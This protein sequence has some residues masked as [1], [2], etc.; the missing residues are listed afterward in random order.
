M[1]QPEMSGNDG[2]PV[3]TLVIGHETFRLTSN[4]LTA[5]Y[6]CDPGQSKWRWLDALWRPEPYMFER[7]G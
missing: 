5:V 4:S 3:N 7:L 6:S 2:V 1:P